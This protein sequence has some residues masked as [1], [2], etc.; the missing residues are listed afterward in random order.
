MSEKITCI[1]P[2]ILIWARETSRVPIE[3]IIKVTG[4]EERLNEWEN[5]KDYPTYSQL[6]HLSSLY[7]KPLAIFFFPEPPKLKNLLISCR[8]LPADIY[9]SFSREIIKVIDDA[10][11]MQLNLLE[12]FKED[13]VPV[14]SFLNFKFNI[15][16]DSINIETLV[17][18]IKSYFEY[19]H[20]KS[21][22]KPS[23]AFEFWRNKFFDFGIYV[24]KD[25]FH[26]LSISGFCLYDDKF[27]VIYINNTLTHT[28]QL[29]TLFH[30]MFHLMNET[31][32]IDFIEELET[33]RY[34]N[35]SN[36]IIE[37]NCNKFASEFLVPTLE[38]NNI[39]KSKSY[40]L[41]LIDNLANQFSV[42][43]EVISRKFLD[44]KIINQDEYNK[45]KIIFDKDYLRNKS[46]TKT[47]SNYYNTI[48][49]YKGKKYIETIYSQYYK[50]Q[51]TIHQM[52]KYLKMK[53]SSLNVYANKHG[54]GDL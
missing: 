47:G 5:A 16:N 49:A 1:N 35:S 8:T 40:S 33:V 22:S 11:V 41:E 7:R 24:F 20:T 32:G 30:E 10:R 23:D 39:I 45:N 29:F 9:L 3:D 13:N 53:I 36:E 48:T 54:W 27:P 21:F 2:E 44:Q 17:K 25:A 52:S 19:S 26:D 51:I 38:F 50:K 31:S 14:N 37:K 34:S 46:I 18:D 15:N 4:S 42:S 43:R 6:K 28:R 12:L